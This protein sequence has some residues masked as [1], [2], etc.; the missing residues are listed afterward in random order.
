MERRRDQGEC[1]AALAGQGTAPTGVQAEQR[2]RTDLASCH[3]F[4]SGGGIG[5]APDVGVLCG[6]Q[7]PLRSGS[8]PS[9]PGTGMA[10]G[11]REGPVA[12]SAGADDQA[13][14][15]EP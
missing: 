10:Y 1:V 7:M 12:C 2:E 4:L 14:R 3:G 8:D 5:P 15:P 6:T 11:T 13:G 9:C